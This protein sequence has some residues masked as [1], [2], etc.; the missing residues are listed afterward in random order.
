MLHDVNRLNNGRIP[1]TGAWESEVLLNIFA[2]GDRQIE[3]GKTQPA[4]D[5]FSELRKL[6][7]K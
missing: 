4:Q 1:E 5:V 2:L 3:E 6:G 7:C